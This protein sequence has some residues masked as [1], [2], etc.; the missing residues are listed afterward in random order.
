MARQQ[1]GISTYFGRWVRFP[2]LSLTCGDSKCPII[3]KERG[4]FCKNCF[5]RVETEKQAISVKVQGTGGDLI[6]MAA[7]RLYK[8]Y[9]Y[10]P[11]ALIHD[12]YITEESD[13]IINVVQANVKHV[14]ESLWNFIVPL[15]AEVKIAK[16]LLESH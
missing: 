9:G 10:V 2:Q 4:Y 1:L 7:L 12:Q 16:N 11:N 14:M 8:E 13:S 6:K 3:D 15:K 5:V